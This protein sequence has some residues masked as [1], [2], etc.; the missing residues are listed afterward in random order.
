MVLHLEV[1]VKCLTLRFIDEVS[2]NRTMYKLSTPSN[3]SYGKG[4]NDSNRTAMQLSKADTH[5]PDDSKLILGFQAVLHRTVTQFRVNMGNDS[6]SLGYN[7]YSTVAEVL[8]GI[9]YQPPSV[10]P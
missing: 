5:I 7:T 8:S 3:S 2:G 10:V 4:N 6:H 1:D 9:S